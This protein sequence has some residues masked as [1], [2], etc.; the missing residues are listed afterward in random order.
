MFPAEFL[1]D[2]QASQ[3]TEAC[4]RRWSVLAGSLLWGRG[5]WSSCSSGITEGSRSAIKHASGMNR[6]LQTFFILLPNSE[7]LPSA[8]LALLGTRPLLLGGFGTLETVESVCRGC[9]CAVLQPGCARQAAPGLQCPS[10]EHV[11]KQIC[12]L[13]FVSI[14]VCT[15]VYAHLYITALLGLHGKKRGLH[16]DPL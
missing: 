5:T 11:E 15:P 9:E 13:I 16:P 6:L 12:K 14:Y 7:T 8:P 4:F 1:L 3:L 2:T 10:A